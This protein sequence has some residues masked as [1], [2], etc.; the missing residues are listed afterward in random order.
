MER[1]RQR[2][3]STGS[4][5]R[6]PIVCCSWAVG[7]QFRAGA[8]LGARQHYARACQGGQCG[9]TGI[10]GAHGGPGPDRDYDIFAGSV[11]AY[12]EVDLGIVRPFL[13]FL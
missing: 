8:G 12:G 13:M 2:G 3:E 5:A 6:R 9:R 11:V 1:I 4:G 10:G 7:G